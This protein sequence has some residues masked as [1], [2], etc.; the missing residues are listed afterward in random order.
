[1]LS[2]SQGSSFA[3]FTIE[4]VLLSAFESPSRISRT[5][6]S[7]GPWQFSQPMANSRNGGSRNLPLPPKTACGHPLWHAMQPGK[8]G[9]L[10]P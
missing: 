2:A 7:P 6:A 8:I 5:C 3:G 10:K 1:M 9:R 4:C